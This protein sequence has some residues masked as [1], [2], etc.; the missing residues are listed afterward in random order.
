M[1]RASVLGMWAGTGADLICGSYLV[2]TLP[3]PSVALETFI[4]ERC[5]QDPHIAVIVSVSDLL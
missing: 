1:V 3:T 5:E 2:I 4:L